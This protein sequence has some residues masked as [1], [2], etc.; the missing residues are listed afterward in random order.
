M[1]KRIIDIRDER[2]SR[3]P[4][5]LQLDS[6]EEEEVNSHVSVN[7]RYAK[8]GFKRGA[9]PMLRKKSQKSNSRGPSPQLSVETRRMTMQEL[10]NMNEEH[11][12]RISEMELRLKKRGEL[13]D[14]IQQQLNLLSNHLGITFIQKQDDLPLP[15]PP[16]MSPPPPLPPPPSMS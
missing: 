16:L 11:R 5:G 6:N 14:R 10:R 9:D 12:R 3:L 1:Q 4:K 13:L 2:L 8:H 7:K 15:P